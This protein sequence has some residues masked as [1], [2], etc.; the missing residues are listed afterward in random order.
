MYT[1]AYEE[2]EGGREHFE[3]RSCDREERLCT[4]VLEGDPRPDR[5]K[6]M[7]R[8]EIDNGK[9]KCRW[10]GLGGGRERTICTERVM[11]KMQTKQI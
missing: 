6:T 11:W 3:G 8:N 1:A 9:V 4:V 10:V 7:R 2:G 5:R